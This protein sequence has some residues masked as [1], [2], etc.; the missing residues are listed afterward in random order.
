MD[1]NVLQLKKRIESL[2]LKELSDMVWINS[3]DYTT[4]AINLAQVELSK[5]G[6]SEEIKKLLAEQEKREQEKREQEKREQ[7][8]ERKRNEKINKQATIDLTEAY[9]QLLGIEKSLN[10]KNLLLKETVAEQLQDERLNKIR[11]DVD[12]LLY[13]RKKMLINVGIIL[14][15]AIGLFIIIYFAIIK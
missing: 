12:A 5:Y 2:S 11:V 7:E 14:G 4:E 9:L 10:E 3:K 8:E 6:S 1:K 13:K 15:V